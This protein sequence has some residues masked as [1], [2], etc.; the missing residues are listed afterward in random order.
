MKSFIRFGVWKFVIIDGGVSTHP[1]L[2]LMARDMDN[3]YDVKVAVTDVTQL[4]KGVA[5]EI[6]EQKNGGHG[7]EEETSTML[8][9]H[10]ELVHMEKAVE[11]YREGFPGCV[12]DG[13]VVVNYPSRMGTPC[14]TNGNSTLAT[15]EKGEK[16]IWAMVQEICNFIDSFVSAKRR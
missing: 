9:I 8:Y 5:G 2:L 16:I 6:C 11:E 4:G 7:D 15:K 13:R 3:E 14:G 10:E 12:V 1:P